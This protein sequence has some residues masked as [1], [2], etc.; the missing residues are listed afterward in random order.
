MLT[1]NTDTTEIAAGVNPV[2]PVETEGAANPVLPVKGAE[3]KKEAEKEEV[4]NPGPPKVVGGVN[5]GLTLGLTPGATVPTPGGV[6]ATLN[7][8]GGKQQEQ[9]MGTGPDPISTVL[10]TKP[11]GEKAVEKAVDEVETAEMQAV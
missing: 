7:G 3:E 10:G 5:E 4:A 9:V 2:P 8:T 6:E 1:R 11:V